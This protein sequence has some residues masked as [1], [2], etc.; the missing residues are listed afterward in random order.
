MNLQ[1]HP[2]QPA[3]TDPDPRSCQRHMLGCGY[4]E[5]QLV[6]SINPRESSV[7]G[8]S[9]WRQQG[10][11]TAVL[12]LQFFYYCKLVLQFQRLFCLSAELSSFSA[13]SCLVLV[14]E[15][16]SKA[17][18]VAYKSIHATWI[19]PHLINLQ[20]QALTEFIGS[21]WDIIVKWQGNGCVHLYSS[22]RSSVFLAA[23]WK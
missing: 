3:Q 14:D 20:P 15:M 12:S 5:M 4:A 11:V 18:P 21:Y 13:A 16:F 19:F 6:W 10:V 23:N 22:V 1:V 9:C 2:Y 17:N 8:I 7:G